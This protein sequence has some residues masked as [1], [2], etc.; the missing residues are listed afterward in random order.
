MFVSG[1]GKE[2]TWMVGLHKVTTGATTTGTFDVYSTGVLSTEI[3]APF[4][5]RAPT[6]EVLTDDEAFRILNHLAT[7]PNTAAAKD[8]SLLTDHNLHIPKGH[9]EMVEIADAS[10]PATNR[11]RL[12]VRDNG[13][14]K[15][16]LVVRFPS[17]AVQTIAT[18]P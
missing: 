10:A 15:T 3:F 1:V 2:W 17:G 12:Y 18:E 4:V 5:Y 11:G 9:M 8:V 6:A 16:Q 13:A 14:G 7:V